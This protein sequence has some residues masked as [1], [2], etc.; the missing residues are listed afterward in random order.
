MSRH[1]T[2]R[3][4]L[5]VLELV[6]PPLSNQ[7]AVWMEADPEVEAILRSSDFYMIVGRAEARYVDVAFDEAIERLTLR[8]LVGD[9]FSDDVV[10]DLM[11]LPTFASH[12]L[13]NY[14]I[15]IGE[16]NIRI[17]T[18]TPNAEGSEVIDWFT[19]EKLLWQRS[20]GVPGIAAFDRYREAATYDLLYVGIAKV[21]DT[22]ERLF[23]NGHKTRSTIL[24]NEPQRRSGAR[25]TDETYL[26]CFKV[27]PLGITTFATDHAF[28]DEDL[29]PSFERKRIVADAE[30]AFVHLLDPG[31][32]AQKF[33]NYPRGA[34]GLYASSYD[35]YGYSLIENVTLQAPAATFRG[36]RDPATGY[37]SNVG[38]SI[39]VEGDTVR[40]LVSGVDFPT[41]YA[42][43]VRA[44]VSH[45]AL[46]AGLA[47]SPTEAD[48]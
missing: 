21:G 17:W 18:G 40:L 28:S 5:S 8:F 10:I 4:K 48:S 24:A 35:R 3:S 36:G 30:K 9:S 20:R 42:D 47:P 19:T 34:D 2:T 46:F 13:T 23:K 39:F 1:P 27:E 41:D 37:I 44:D 33:K 43:Q 16:K 25:V 14:Q 7:E 45:D 15:E 32:N 6:Y 26:L 22:F 38:D 12:Q 31:Y 29:N 11:S